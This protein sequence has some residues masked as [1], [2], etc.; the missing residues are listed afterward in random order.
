MLRLFRIFFIDEKAQNTREDKENIDQ[1][2]RTR[3][4]AITRNEIWKVVGNTENKSAEK[5]E[6]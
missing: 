3:S 1:K 6:G 4:S 5:K 2:R